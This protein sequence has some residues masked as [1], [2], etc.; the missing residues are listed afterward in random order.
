MNFSFQSENNDKE[1]IPDE[2]PKNP[3]LTKDHVPK[4]IIID[5]NIM[6]C[7]KKEYEIKE[8]IKLKNN[9]VNEFLDDIMIY[10]HCEKCKKYENKFENKYFCK[11]CFKNICDNCYEKCQIEKHVIVNLE[12]MKEESISNIKIIKNFVNNNIIPI[13]EVNENLTK[14]E[15]DEDIFLIIEIIS[16]DYINYF[17][18]ENI[19][20]ILEYI[21]FYKHKY[22]VEKYEGFGKLIDE[23]G[24]YYIGQFKDDLRNGKGTLYNKNGNIIYEGDWI[25]NKKEG[26]G[27]WI[28]EDGK[29]Y[30]GQF[31][32]N[33]INGKGTLYNKNG[34]IIY[35][36]D[37]INDKKEGNGN[38]LMK[39]MNII[40]ANL[41]MV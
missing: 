9:A 31:K 4:L 29:Y 36:G 12:K 19:R 39:M 16:Q 1:N 10:N 24:Y 21:D 38:L 6:F 7:D 32:D 41:K 20:K 8:Y 14:K 30:I 27:K 3:Y 11:N 34:N 35:E 5:K 23:D 18:L 13:K 33:L 2:L 17:H 25:N 22:S 15:N 28:F 26:N 37:W 40:Q